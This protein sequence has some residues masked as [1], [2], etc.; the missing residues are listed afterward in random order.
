MRRKASKMLDFVEVELAFGRLLH[1]M[2]HRRARKISAKTAGDRKQEIAQL[3]QDAHRL[4]A[5]LSPST[6]EEESLKEKA[7]SE[8]LG[9]KSASS[10]PAQDIP[11][12]KD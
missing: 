12:P 5:L 3:K 6:L 11:V 2:E 8:D 1:D 9:L 10:T 4:L 7:Q